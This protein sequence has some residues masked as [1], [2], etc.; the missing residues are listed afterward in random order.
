MEILLVRHTSVNV[1]HQLCYGFTDVEL[2][3]G[4]KAEFNIVKAK[5]PDIEE[6]QIISSPLSRCN[7]LAHFLAPSK[8]QFDERIKEMNFGDWELK[9]W[10]SIDKKALGN[11]INDYV[12]YQCPS[13][14]SFLDLYTRCIS[15]YQ[16]LDKKNVPGIVVV[17]H[18]GVI[19][20]I[21][22]YE[23]EIPLKKSHSLKI[24]FGSI[25]R[26]E[27]INGLTY[28]SGINI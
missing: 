6:Y 13:G 27:V 18:G 15:F 20:S 4:Y 16:E 2:S 17:T 22:S 3:S 25:S 12:Y 11:W 14:E 9:N 8:V 21:L 1:D 26:I 24:D 19:R 5:L 23:L 7:K 28:V 10:E